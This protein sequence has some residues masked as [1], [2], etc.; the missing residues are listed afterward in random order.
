MR[1]ILLHQQHGRRIVA[2]KHDAKWQDYLCFELIACTGVDLLR[3]AAANP[4]TRDDDGGEAHG[5]IANGCANIV[6][7]NCRSEWRKPRGRKCKGM[8]DHFNAYDSARVNFFQ[9]HAAGDVRRTGTS[10]CIDKGSNC[11]GIIDCTAKGKNAGITVADGYWHRIENWNKPIRVSGE[12]YKTEVDAM[13]VNCTGPIYVGPGATVTIVGKHGRI[14]RH[15][16]GVVRFEE[17]TRAGA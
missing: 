11:C 14:E 8:E 4:E 3:C 1:H 16:R 12:W 2:R 10:F 17:G 6:F 13:L 15:D 7:R 5:F 9:C